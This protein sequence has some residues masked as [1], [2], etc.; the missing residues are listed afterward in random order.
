MPN[1]L[2]TYLTQRSDASTF[3]LPAD[4]GRTL[5]DLFPRPEALLP[6]PYK[7]FPADETQPPTLGFPLAE[8]PVLKELDAKLDK[9]LA[10]EVTWQV[11]RTARRKK[12]R[13]SRSRRTSRS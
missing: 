11:S 1:G 4:L 3:L 13:R 5:E 10:E 12:K 9:W 8:S 2:V 6:H 7:I